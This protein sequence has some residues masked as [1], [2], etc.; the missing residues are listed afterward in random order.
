M[1][2]VPK[3][4]VRRARQ[5]LSGGDMQQ[6][7]AEMALLQGSVKAL[8]YELAK[9]IGNERLGDARRPV[10]AP[11]SIGLR[12]KSTNQD[13]MESPWLWYWCQQLG[14]PVIYHRKVWELAYILQ[15]MWEQDMLQPGRRGLGFGCG[16]EPIP[17]LVARYGVEL[18]VTDQEPS[19]AENGGWVSTDQHLG[20]LDQAFH[21]DLI[22]RDAFDRQVTIKFVDMNA[23]AQDLQDYDFCWSTCA[24]EHL[25]SIAAGQDF[26]VKAMRVLKP[27]G[28]A[29]HTTEM[30]LD[31]DG[32][33]LETK[34]L[35]LFQ[36]RHFEEIGDRLR[37]QG[38]EPAS[39]DFALGTGPIDE[40]M[41]VPPYAQTGEGFAFS[42]VRGD[43]YP[44][45]MAHLRL[46]VGQFPTTCFGLWARRGGAAT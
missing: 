1:K 18:T 41:D 22:N 33:T 5:M 26:V 34:D 36:R 24:F 37:K 11:V 7:R 28:I 23:I 39:M 3:A 19:T 45:R 15:V 46:T 31:P 4:A 10:P 21:P 32:P 16:Q 14:I 35:V 12:S 44:D 17:S 29:I 40:F 38:D 43:S 25:G 9:R 2:F 30:N 20:S 27:G 13:D 8:G 6:M 42:A